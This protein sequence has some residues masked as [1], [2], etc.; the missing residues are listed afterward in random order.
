MKIRL[1][2]DY[3][4]KGLLHFSLIAVSILVTAPSTLPFNI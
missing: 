4:L 2:N 3:T 1:V